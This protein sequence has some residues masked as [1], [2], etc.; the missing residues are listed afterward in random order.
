M[1]FA[2]FTLG[3]LTIKLE[4]WPYIFLPFLAQSLL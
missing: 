4:D 1:G 3:V 2:S